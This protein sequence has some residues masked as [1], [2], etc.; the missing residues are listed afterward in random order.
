MEREGRRSSITTRRS[1]P[2]FYGICS[3]Y[4]EDPA[5]WER[6]GLVTFGNKSP[7]AVNRDVVLSL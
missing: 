6:K 7:C 2:L 3:R 5:D 1:Q 4:A